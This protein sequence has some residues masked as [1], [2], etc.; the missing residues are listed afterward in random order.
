[1]GK[2]KAL[3]SICRMMA[4]PVVANACFRVCLCICMWLTISAKCD[5]K[6]DG[7]GLGERDDKDA[8]IDK[9]K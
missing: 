6:R 4:K 2:K 3:R 7:L 5:D 8:E 9:K 1:M